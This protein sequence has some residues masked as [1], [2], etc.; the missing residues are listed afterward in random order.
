MLAEGDRVPPQQLKTLG[1]ADGGESSVDCV[2]V[3]F[4]RTG[5]LE[6]KNDGFGSTVPEPGRA[7]RTVEIGVDA[8]CGGKKSAVGYAFG[9]PA[10]GAHWP[11]RV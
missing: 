3:D 1:L 2:G 7:E 11:Y 9:E 10:G 8:S 6:P 4:V 5:A